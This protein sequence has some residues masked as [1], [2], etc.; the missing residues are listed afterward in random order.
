MSDPTGV[1]LVV[2][3]GGLVLIVLILAGIRSWERVRIAQIE[4]STQTE[5][6][7]TRTRR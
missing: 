3:I 1:V 6:P 7:P 4:R 2:G 5:H